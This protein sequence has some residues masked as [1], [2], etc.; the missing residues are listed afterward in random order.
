M[1]VVVGGH[2]RKTGKTAVVCALIRAVA[3][4]GWTAVKI[5]RHAHGGGAYQIDEET[6]PGA[7]DTGRYLAAGARRAFLVRTAPG[8]LSAAMP[9]VRGILDLGPHAIVESNSILEFVRP[10][11]YLAVAAAD[12]PEF[13]ESAGR[14]FARADAIVVVDAGDVPG[15]WSG[16]PR[17]PVAPPLFASPE[18]AELVRARL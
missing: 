18:L 5:A 16:R 9:A 3:E 15:A 8:G 17:F 13:K 10:D 7:T 4:A 1:L 2:A 11:L 6:A 12:R 14:Y